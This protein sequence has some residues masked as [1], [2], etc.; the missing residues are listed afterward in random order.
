M[1]R[2]CYYVMLPNSIKSLQCCQRDGSDFYHGQTIDYYDKDGN[3][4]K[5]ESRNVLLH[6][7]REPCDLEAYKTFQP[8]INVFEK[9]D[10]KKLKELGEEFYGRSRHSNLTLN[11]ETPPETQ[12]TT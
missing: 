10:S 2:L 12:K 6:S 8:H 1:N 3:Y 11:T 9:S 4:L 5:R 7:V